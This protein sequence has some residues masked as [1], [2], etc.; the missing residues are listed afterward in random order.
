[1][2]R[3]AHDAVAEQAFALHEHQELAPWL[4][5]IHEVGRRVGHESAADVAVALHRVVVWLETDLQAHAAWEES[6]LYPEIDRRAGTPWASR[7][8]RFEHQQIRAAVRN[9]SAEQTTLQHE[10]TPATACQVA[11]HVFGLEAILRGHLERE[12]RVL[13][14]LLDDQVDSSLGR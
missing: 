3:L 12:E 8:M 1:M 13:L 11:S 4:D 10:L 14:P 6:W 9:L 2:T 5:R 7:T